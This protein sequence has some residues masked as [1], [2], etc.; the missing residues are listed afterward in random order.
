MRY[1]ARVDANQPGIVEALKDAGATIVHLHQ[2]GEGIPDILVGFQGKC[3][4]VE[5]KSGNGKLT[6]DQ[7][8]FMGWWRGYATTLRSVREALDWL[9]DLEAE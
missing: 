4:L 5:I 3:Y 6:E 1:K 9:Q 7:E 8:K 2:L